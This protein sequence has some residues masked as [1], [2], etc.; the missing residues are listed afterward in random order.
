MHS[1]RPPPTA[2]PPQTF[3]GGSGPQPPQTFGAGARP[4]P[5]R[6]RCQALAASSLRP[7]RAHTT[8]PITCTFSSARR[9][10]GPS[11][12]GSRPAPPSPHRLLLPP[13]LLR[14]LTLPPRLSLTFCFLLGC[15]S[16]GRLRS[17]RLLSRLPLGSS[18]R[19]CSCGTLLRRLLLNLLLA[20]P[21]LGLQ[22][23][24]TAASWTAGRRAFS[25]TAGV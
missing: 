6:C 10:A 11:H 20:L 8:L 7:Q 21:L 5:N 17:G 23:C 9:P 4:A 16:S 19:S 3:G 22:G 15:G 12:P 14:Y 24:E 13:P 1:P 25:E 18:R 2:R